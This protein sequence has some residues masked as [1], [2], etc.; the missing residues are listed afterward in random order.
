MSVELSIISRKDLEFIN[1]EVNALELPRT[2][3]PVKPKETVVVEEDY[4]TREERQVAIGGLIED[5][6]KILAPQDVL[7]FQEQTEECCNL[8][9]ESKVTSSFDLDNPSPMI[10]TEI[11]ENKAKLLTYLTEF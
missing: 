8:E 1:K 3:I 11:G 2:E 7:F 6:S 4:L 10:A 5:I 9:G